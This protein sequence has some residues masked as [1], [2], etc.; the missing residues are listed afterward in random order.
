MN[1]APYPITGDTVEEILPKLNS[2]IKT[3]YEDC[4]GGAKLG[5]V[6]S[7]PGDVLTLVLD[8]NA[9]I[10]KTNNELGIYVDDTTIRAGTDGLET[11]GSDTAFTVITALQAGVGPAGVDYKIRTMTLTNGLLTSIGEESDWISI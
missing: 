6:F 10:S 8:D 1:S 7:V 5:D 3:L 11:I 9:P 2:F 4:V